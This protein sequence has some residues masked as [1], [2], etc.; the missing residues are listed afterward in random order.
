MAIDR[1]KNASVGTGTEIWAGIEFFTILPAVNSHETV[2][3]LA[4]QY[5][6]MGADKI[7]LYNFYRECIQ[8]AGGMEKYGFTDISLF[9]DYSQYESDDTRTR[10]I[11]N[12]ASD[13]ETAARSVRR[14]ILS[15]SDIVPDGYRS[16][17]PLPLYYNGEANVSKLTGEIKG[18]KILLYLGVDPQDCA[19]EVLMDGITAA[20]IG[21]TDDAYFSKCEICGGDRGDLGDVVYYAYSAEASSGFTR[22]ITLRGKGRLSYLEIKVT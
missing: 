14:H 13:Y 21:L 6:E 2:S 7:Y 8:D 19:P 4:A 16:D 11:W 12:A 3:A 5:C 15:P 10:K 22:R 20:L 9:K 17:Y 1:W 18:K